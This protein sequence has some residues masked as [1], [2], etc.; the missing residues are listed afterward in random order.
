M[1]SQTRQASIECKYIL[2]HSPTCGIQCKYIEGSHHS[3]A[4]NAKMHFGVHIHT[5][6]GGGRFSWK[7]IL[8]TERRRTMRIYISGN[9][10]R[11]V[12]G[13]S[14]L[15]QEKGKRLSRRG[16]RARFALNA[17]SFC[18]THVGCICLHNSIS[19]R[20]RHCMDVVSGYVVADYVLGRGSATGCGYGSFPPRGAL[21]PA[22]MGGACRA[23]RG[24]DGAY[25]GDASVGLHHHAHAKSEL[26]GA[27]CSRARLAY[28]MMLEATGD[29][30]KAI[31][32]GRRME[33]RSERRLA[34]ICN[35]PAGSREGRTRR[36]GIA[37]RRRRAPAPESHRCTR[38]EEAP[39]H[40][41]H[42]SRE[43]VLED[44]DRRL[45]QGVEV[46][47]SIGAP[48]GVPTSADDGRGSST[49]PRASA[50]VRGSSPPIVEAMLSLAVGDRC[51]L[52]VNA[53]T[54]VESTHARRAAAESRL[55]SSVQHSDACREAAT[56][57]CSGS[58]PASPDDWIKGEAAVSDAGPLVS[59][60]LH[61]EQDPA[62]RLEE[63][64]PLLAP[65]SP[66]EP[67][68]A[69]ALR[70][71]DHEPSRRAAEPEDNSPYARWALS[72]FCSRLRDRGIS[73]LPPRYGPVNPVSLSATGLG[74]LQRGVKLR[75][76]NRHSP[77]SASAPAF[78]TSGCVTGWEGG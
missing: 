16:W 62:P 12:H 77:T 6:L 48:M 52:D 1:Q 5:S 44:T 47:S 49:A 64:P 25:G 78:A 23:A 76:H 59:L 35:G 8:R 53:G 10:R 11:E 41:K 26:P 27:P 30:A 55:S 15:R 58:R 60:A 32:A 57:V 3:I 31:R 18:P 65:A 29:E 17:C 14:H 61:S 20:S 21:S 13:D 73:A 69:S 38:G 54:G 70:S 71:G 24:G 51:S 22:G 9:D 37:A 67:A 56:T 72:V 45:R 39:T 2:V 34:A 42:I 68:V 36:R 74:L 50:E 66:A 7:P 19:A 40:S 75:E 43:S 63:V 33:A 28:C 4:F 46:T